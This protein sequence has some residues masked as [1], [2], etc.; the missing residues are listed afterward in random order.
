MNKTNGIIIALLIILIGLVGYSILKPK[1]I[2]STPIETPIVR[3]SVDT[4]VVTTDTKTVSN[5]KTTTTGQANWFI[6]NQAGWVE[7]T[8]LWKT[9]SIGNV[10]F[11]YPPGYIVTTKKQE[12]RQGVF[13]N[14]VTITD[15]NSR[16]ETDDTI[17]VGVPY[18]GAN[19]P[20]TIYEIKENANN[21]G[22]DFAV[23]LQASNYAKYIFSNIVA[24]VTKK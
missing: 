14:E 16:S 21:S 24:S 19:D 20:N 12:T 7:H 6:P 15:P 10:T 9:Y 17:H 2:I 5:P 11:N 22:I 3:N 13:V 18:V 1:D 23:S 8:L 4:P